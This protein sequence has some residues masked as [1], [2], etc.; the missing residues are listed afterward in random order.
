MAGGRWLHRASRNRLTSTDPPASCAS[1][2]ILHGMAE[3]SEAVEDAQTGA[4][5][6]APVD[7]E[8]PSAGAHGPEEAGV[9]CRNCGAMVTGKFCSECAQPAHIHRSLLSLTHDVLHSVFHF[10]GKLWRTVPALVLHPGE[11]TRRYIDGERARFVSPM[12]LFLFTV[13]TMFAV[14]SFVGDV[15]LTAGNDITDVESS[16]RT[17]IETTDRKISDLRQRL[18][19]PGLASDQHAAI[20]RQIADLESWRAVTQAL[21]FGRD[22]SS[23]ESQKETKAP[24]SAR[25]GSTLGLNQVMEALK[26]NPRLLLYKLKTNGYK[27]S[28]ALVPMSIPFMWLLFFWRR[29]I[30]LYDHAVFVTYSIS[31]MMLLAILSVLLGAAGVSSDFTEALLFFVPPVHIYR[32]LRGAY[33]L[34]R[35]SALA[36]LFF[37]LIAAVLVLGLFMMLLLLIG[38][39]G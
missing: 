7:R 25:P 5:V 11:L 12:A 2:A 38:A 14:F 31:F 39:L 24:E 3:E 19:D 16:H 9:A 36:R 27:F 29:D 23:T 21:S 10:D 13:F 8:A 32:Q 28:W 15:A 35:A 1:D 6:P 33:G 20:E 30:H 18:A 26:N 37:V 22:G 34:S 4:A 17:A